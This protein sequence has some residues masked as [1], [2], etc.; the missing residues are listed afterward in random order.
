MAKTVAALILGAAMLAGCQQKVVEHYP[1]PNLD[2]PV[3]SSPQDAGS[4]AV[5]Q[6]PTTAP[7]PKLA[8]SGVPSEWLPAAPANPWQWIVIHHSATPSGSAA[9]FDQA[10]RLKGWDELGYHFVIGNGIG[11]P[12]GRIE[13]GPRWVHQKHGAHA[14]TPDNRFNDFGIGICLVGNFD[15]DRPTAAQ[16]RSVARLTAYLMQTYH[17]GADHVLGHSDCKPTDCPGRHVS[18]A[19]IR[20]MASRIAE[21]GALQAG[22]TLA[23]TVAA[24]RANAAMAR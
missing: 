1:L 10:H 17:I 23:H 2:G 5:V 7:S 9:S 16:I 24:G 19:E 15:L 6:G 11:S 8:V 13:V 14:K 20:R 22:P 21:A 4:A 18:V 3:V 12:D